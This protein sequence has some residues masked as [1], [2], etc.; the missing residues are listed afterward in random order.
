MFLR[1]VGIRLRDSCM[2]RT[3][4]CTIQIFPRIRKS[5][6]KINRSESS[7]VLMQNDMNTK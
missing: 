5:H 2:T 3:F 1:N 4:I 7:S 6:A